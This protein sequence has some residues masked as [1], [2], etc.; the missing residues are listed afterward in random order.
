VAVFSKQKEEFKRLYQEAE[1]KVKELSSKH[2]EAQKTIRLPKT[3][4][5]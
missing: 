1:Q 4:E 3:M 5:D 2:T